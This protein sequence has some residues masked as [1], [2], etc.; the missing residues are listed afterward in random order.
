MTVMPFGKFAGKR[1]DEVP[2][3][4]LQWMLDKCTNLTDSFR[5]DVEC[6]V[7]G[8]PLPERPADELDTLEKQLAAAMGKR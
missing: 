5:A 4:Y 3:R 2:S 1:L 8:L 6:V 7:K